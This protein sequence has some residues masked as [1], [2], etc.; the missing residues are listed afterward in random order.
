ME[1]DWNCDDDGHEWDTDDVFNSF[2]RNTTTEKWCI[3]CDIDYDG[4]MYDWRD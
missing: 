2:T 1:E 3:H 4:E